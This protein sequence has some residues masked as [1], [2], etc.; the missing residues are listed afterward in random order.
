M[1]K[2]QETESRERLNRDYHKS[3]DKSTKIHWVYSQGSMKLLKVAQRTRHVTISLICFNVG[4]EKQVVVY[5][6]ILP[7]RLSIIKSY[8]MKNELSSDELRDPVLS[9]MLLSN[10]LAHE[11]FSELLLFRIL[12]VT[13]SLAYELGEIIPQKSVVTPGSS[14]DPVPALQSSNFRDNNVFINDIVKYINSSRER[15]L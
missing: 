11:K 2:Q 7:F 4:E 10:M 14:F 15:V 8:L 9:K 13:K 5:V 12:E 1:H 3:F 6:W